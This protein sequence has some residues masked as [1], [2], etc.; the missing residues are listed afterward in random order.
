VF[1]FL[2]GLL[3]VVVA[4]FLWLSA[5]WFGRVL[6]FLIFAPVFGLLVG[7]L[8]PPPTGANYNWGG[9]VIGMFLAYP[10]SGIPRYWQAIMQRRLARRPVVRLP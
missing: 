10:V 2:L 4:L 9:L 6:A 8:T 1:A 5:H 7:G 3:F